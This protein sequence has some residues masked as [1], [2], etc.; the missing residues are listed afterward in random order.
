[1]ALIFAKAWPDAQIVRDIVPDERDA[2][3][4]AFRRAADADWIITTGGTGPAP[5]DVTPEATREWMDREMPG[6]AEML[7]AA[8]LEETP[9]AVFSR[10]TAGMRGLQYIVNVPGSVKAARLCATLLAPILEHGVKMARGEGH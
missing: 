8:S 7:R 3:L 6:I 10:G 4:A 5:R 2:L 1:M 9:H